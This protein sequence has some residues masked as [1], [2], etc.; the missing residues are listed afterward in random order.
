MYWHR[1]AAIQGAGTSSP[2]ISSTVVDEERMMSGHWIGLVHYVSFSALALMVGWKD[3]S[4]FSHNFNGKTPCT[5]ITFHIWIRNYS[6]MWQQSQIHNQFVQLTIGSV[7]YPRHSVTVRIIRILFLMVKHVHYAYEKWL[8]N[9]L[10]YVKLSL[11][12]I[13]TFNK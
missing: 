2:F 9:T 12:F 5:L 8:Y 11:L 10:K 13:N 6:C 3:I 1:R 7:I 4:S